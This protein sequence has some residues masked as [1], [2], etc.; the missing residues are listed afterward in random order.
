MV[1]LPGARRV[2]VERRRRRRDAAVAGRKD[3]ARRLCELLKG[4]AEELGYGPATAV[5]TACGGAGAAVRKKMS[6]RAVLRAR[7]DAPG[8][9]VAPAGRTDWGQSRRT[10]RPGAEEDGGREEAA[11][12]GGR[13]GLGA[14]ETRGRCHVRV[15][16]PRSQ[17]R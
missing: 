5:Q 15:V 3:A 12:A 2:I 16:H 7:L 8:G 1:M 10:G 13:R 4:A 6:R 11:R 14:G 17:Q 9:G